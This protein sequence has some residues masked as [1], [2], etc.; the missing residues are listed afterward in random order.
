MGR[1]AGA[2]ISKLQ[3]MSQARKRAEEKKRGVSEQ[4]RG[5]KQSAIDKRREIQNR[6]LDLEI[7]GLESARFQQETSQAKADFNS[8][9]NQL[10]MNAQSKADLAGVLAG[11]GTLAGMGAGIYAGQ[12][13]AK[14]PTGPSYLPASDE[15]YATGQYQD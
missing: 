5:A 2:D 15:Y 11:V 14:E 7:Q 1:L 13:G 8:F 9:I 12:P 6:L 4:V 3:T 10:D